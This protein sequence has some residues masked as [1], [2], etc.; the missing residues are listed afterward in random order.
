M[1]EEREDP[2]KPLIKI[3]TSPRDLLEDQD[4]SIELIRCNK[5]KKY[6]IDRP[7]EDMAKI[8]ENL[9]YLIPKRQEELETQEIMLSSFIKMKIIC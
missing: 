8:F 9:D 7:E 2:K 4:N 1:K 6:A 5:L 3:L